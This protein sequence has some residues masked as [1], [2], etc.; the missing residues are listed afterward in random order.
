M[1]DMITALPLYR[2]IE[3]FSVCKNNKQIVL[4]IVLLYCYSSTLPGYA[5]HIMVQL[6]FRT[7]MPGIEREK[8]KA[9]KDQ[10]KDK[11]T[12]TN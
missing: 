4:L 2:N 6:G 1:T 5:V 9:K 11:K 3:F 12:S 10:N 8:D 7:D